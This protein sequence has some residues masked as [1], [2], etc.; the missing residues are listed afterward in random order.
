MG[1]EKKIDTKAFIRQISTA[2][3]NAEKQS[4]IVE[5]NAVGCDASEEE[6]KT[7]TVLK[8]TNKKRTTSVKL[9]YEEVFLTRNELSHRQGLYIGKEQ[10]EA[11]QSLVRS[12][13]NE[14]ISV[15]GLVDNIVKHHIELYG[16]EINR[17]FDE[18]IRKPINK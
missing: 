6:E 8:E 3:N 7:K 4:S 13:R 14:R 12:I 2:G 11:L 10:Y 17:I 9:N 16:E 5:D 15:S 18:N 1:E